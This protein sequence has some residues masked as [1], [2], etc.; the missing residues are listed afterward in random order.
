MARKRPPNRVH[1]SPER[2]GIQN[3]KGVKMEK[4]EMGLMKHLINIDKEGKRNNQTY[5]GLWTPEALS[6]EIDKFFA[7]CAENDFKPTIP[8][9]CTWL[10]ISKVQFWEWRTKPEKHGDKTNLANRAMLIM[11]S[12]LQ[13]NI[14]KYPTGSIFLLKTSHGHAETSKIEVTSKGVGADEI[15]DKIKKMGLEKDKGEE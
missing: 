10:A 6:E 4:D 11:E 8:A 12:F 15:A 3:M 5:K 14:D 7:Y 9:I 13:S 2:A 1:T